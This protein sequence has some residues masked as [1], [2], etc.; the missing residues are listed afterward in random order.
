MN[1]TIE[2][3]F[4]VRYDDF[5]QQIEDPVRVPTFNF[6]DRANDRG[7]NGAARFQVKDDP[8]NMA[9]SMEVDAALGMFANEYA[10]RRLQASNY[11]PSL[12]SAGF[13]S[14]AFVLPVAPSTGNW[15]PNSSYNR[16]M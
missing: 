12:T 6:L 2:S 8:I 4:N 1:N 16:L 10:G 11:Q 14:N 3:G 5:R 13:H 7:V 9:S 15:V